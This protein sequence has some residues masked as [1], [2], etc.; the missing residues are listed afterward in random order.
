MKTT[1]IDWGDEIIIP[2]L[3]ES[4]KDKNIEESPIEP[5]SMDKEEEELNIQEETKISSINTKIEEENIQIFD[6]EEKIDIIPPDVKVRKER[7]EI[8]FIG[9][10]LDEIAI[11]ET[12]KDDT[13]KERKLTINEEAIK[14][15]VI[16][17]EDKE[18]EQ[19]ESIESV[20]SDE[21]ADLLLSIR[22]SVPPPTMQ[23]KIIPRNRIYSVESSSDPIVS[24]ES[25]EN[26]EKIGVTF[27]SRSEMI[28]STGSAPASRRNSRKNADKR[29]ID[30]LEFD[31]KA[32]LEVKKQTEEDEK[33]NILSTRGS[34]NENDIRLKVLVQHT[35]KT[36]IVYCDLKDKL[37]TLFNLILSKLELSDAVGENFGLFHPAQKNRIPSY[38]TIKSLHMSNDALLI[39]KHLYDMY[40]PPK[41]KKQSA[42]F[43]ESAKNFLRIP[44]IPK[45]D[46]SQ[47]SSDSDEKDELLPKVYHGY[48]DSPTCMPVDINI[49]QNF[50][51]WL[52][53]NNGLF[54]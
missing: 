17:N 9:K 19:E 35:E 5:I 54:C 15:E 50:L 13:E 33:K 18:A 42:K 20:E 51:N 43:R 16:M 11:H 32:L 26:I 39:F 34:I 47:N 49:L 2:E 22:K 12:N 14:I 8:K 23:S 7:K 44:K 41:K 1:R 48:F 36:L 37:S 27:Q 6:K 52:E 24:K 10:T 28:H 38:V 53:A 25:D 29:L 45:E 40:T 3:I 4:Q 46:T 30:T 21:E 31:M